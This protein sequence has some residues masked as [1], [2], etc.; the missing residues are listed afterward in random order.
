MPDDRLDPRRVYAKTAAGTAEVSRHSASLSVPA[1]RLLLLLDGRRPLAALPSVVRIGELPRLIGD[2]LSAGLIAPIGLVE[3]L[4]P[5]AGAMRDPR[6]EAFKRRIRGAV[7]RELGPAGAVLEARLQDCVNMTVMRGVM[8]EVV[9]TVR[10]R[11][12]SA[13][14][15]RLAAAA[16]SAARATPAPG[17]E[18]LSD[19]Q[20]SPGEGP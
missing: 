10:I 17:S 14:A 3:T 7:T 20:T 16:Q 2:L 5:E 13:A 18:S 8:R 1:R 15:G 4:P 11:A 9:E 19:P 6:L 12:G